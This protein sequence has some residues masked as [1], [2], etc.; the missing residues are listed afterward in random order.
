MSQYFF[1]GRVKLEFMHPS[2]RTKL[3]ACHEQDAVGI[4]ELHWHS[5]YYGL[6]GVSI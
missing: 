5:V 3:A 1:V 4:V 6:I 2:G